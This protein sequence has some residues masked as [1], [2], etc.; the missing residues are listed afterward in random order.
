MQLQTRGAASSTQWRACGAN[1]LHMPELEN[2]APGDERE[3]HLMHSIAAAAREVERST[4]F[5]RSSGTR[6]REECGVVST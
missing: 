5:N 2:G 6:G 1:A 3:F 4:S